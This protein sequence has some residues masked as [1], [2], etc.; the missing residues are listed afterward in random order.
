MLFRSDQLVDGR[1]NL[2]KQ[3]IDFQQLGVAVKTE[4]AEQWQDRARL[5]LT[6]TPAQN[7]SAKQTD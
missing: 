1:G 6:H 3:A 5:E 7:P 4:I 2:V